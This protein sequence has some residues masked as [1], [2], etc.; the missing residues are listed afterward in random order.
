MLTDWKSAFC[1]GITLGSPV[2]PGYF[3]H[4]GAGVTTIVTKVTIYHSLGMVC[5]CMAIFGFKVTFLHG[6]SAQ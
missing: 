6:L 5:V 1:F 4:P 3:E 2:F